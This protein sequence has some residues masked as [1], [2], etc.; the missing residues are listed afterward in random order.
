MII[1]DLIFVCLYWQWGKVALRAGWGERRK[2]GKEPH[3][4]VTR[5]R[6]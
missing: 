2:D 5:G 3:E 4:K 6:D 1:I